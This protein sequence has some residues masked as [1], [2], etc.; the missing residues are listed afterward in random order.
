MP[1]LRK[2][3]SEVFYNCLLANISYY[4]QMQGWDKMH[5]SKVT[6]ICYSTIVS[7]LQ[8][9]TRFKVEQIRRIADKL[10][11]TVNDLL[12]PKQRVKE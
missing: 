12:T 10:G 5:L 3:E 7:N 11:V 2:N 8:T 1:R 6:G 4:M 9:P